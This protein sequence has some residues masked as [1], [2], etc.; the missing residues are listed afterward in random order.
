MKVGFVLVDAEL[1]VKRVDIHLG[2]ESGDGS[3]DG[4]LTVNSL[5]I[6][7]FYNHGGGPVYARIAAGEL[8]ELPENTVTLGNIATSQFKQFVFLLVQSFLYSNLRIRQ[9]NHGQ[10]IQN[11]IGSSLRHDNQLIL[12]LIQV[13]IKVD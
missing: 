3:H 13:H 7:V 2:L 6:Y 12:A 10:I 4:N 9:H 11:L 5:I 8:I 1:Q